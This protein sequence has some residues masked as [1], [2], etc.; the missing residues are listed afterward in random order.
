M[1]YRCPTCRAEIG[2]DDVNVARDVALCRSC[3]R[4]HSFADLAAG[5]APSP[6]PVEPPS[7]A[8]YEETFDGFRMGAV[9][10][11]CLAVFLVP[12]ACVWI[13]G[14]LG[15]I[16]GSQVVK[17]QFD[18]SASLFGIPFLLGSI[19]LGSLTLM[20]LFGKVVVTVSGDDGSVF[21]G[22]GPIGWTRRFAFSAVHSAAEHLGYNRNGGPSPVIRLAG[23]HPMSFGSMLTEPRR[24][25]LLGILARAIRDRGSNAHKPN[26]GNLADF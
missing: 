19:L 7:G 21:T 9:T 10:R 22:V 3:E 18:L 14:S 24:Q 1:S 2:L 26:S 8:W 5:D 20:T 23:A 12:F 16:Y 25:F 15:G 6:Y 11:S 13:G 17:G 4:T